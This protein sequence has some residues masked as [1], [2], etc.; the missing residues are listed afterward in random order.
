MTALN[1][2]QLSR[3]VMAAFALIALMMI[4]LGVT[5][6]ITTKQLGEVATRHVERGVAGT[7]A[8]GRVM[9]LLREHR[10]IAFSQLNAETPAEIAK[11]DDRFAKNKT[12]LAEAISDYSDVAGEFAP[13]VN[14]MKAD[15]AKLED[16]NGR[17]FATK[18]NLGAAAAL[19]LIKGEGKDASYKAIDE[20]ED[21]IDMHQKRA[22]ASNE[23]G[24]ASARR[25]LYLIEVLL[26]VAIATLFAIWWMIAKTVSTPISQV[27]AVTKRLAEGGEA[28]VP[29]RDRNDEIGDVAKA[30][31]MF[32][33]AAVNRAE[34]DRRNAAEQQ[35]VTSSLGTGLAALTQGDLTADVSADFPPAYAQLKTNFNDALAALRDL[36]GGVS[37]S[38]QTIRTGSGEIAHASEDLARRTEANAASLEE[39]SA[40]L[41]QIDG[42]L[43]ATAVA[44]TRTLERA[45]QAIATVGGG[46][47]VA[48]EAVQAMVR[49]SDS[50]RGID[51]VI[52][53]VDKIAFQTRVLAMNAAVE[54][55]RAGDAGRG[56]AVVADL[57]SALAMRAEEEAK[58]ARDQLTVTQADIG[59]AVDA[60][61]KV[62]GA[63]ANISGD[64]GEVHTLLSTMAADNKAQ[65]SAISEISTAIGTMDH[66]TQQNAA[67][68]EQTSAAARNLNGEVTAL[69]EQAGRFTVDAGARRQPAPRTATPAAAPAKSFVPAAKSAAP[70]MASAGGDD[71]W[72]AF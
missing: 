12:A 15:V 32:R 31:E 1:N 28:V 51:S 67:M 24:Q 7:E 36:V 3:K 39:T 23:A 29:H 62:D 63:L 65:S 69:T 5:G 55:G 42:R 60:V 21:L 54:A 53:G 16:I 48:D 43:K 25:S 64:V 40:A 52:E 61:Q 17:I 44:A 14:E 26:A 19:P 2:W 8:L 6:V 35:I 34:A 27:S 59:T 66:A 58:R 13:Q 72:T 18:K 9:S 47:S 49:V 4:G 10:I 20:A 38:A 57:V 50:A 45:D 30:V 70:A 33:Q 56:F 22:E 41:T 11:L 46:R 68:V 37:E 71:D